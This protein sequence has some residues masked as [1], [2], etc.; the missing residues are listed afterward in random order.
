[1]KIEEKIIRI[2]IPETLNELLEWCD[3]NIVNESE[4]LGFRLAIYKVKK[5]GLCP[6]IPTE[7]LSKVTNPPNKFVG[8]CG[9]DTDALKKNKNDKRRP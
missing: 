2:E 8:F 9:S 7:I 6:L 1:M 4:K 5:L 3:K